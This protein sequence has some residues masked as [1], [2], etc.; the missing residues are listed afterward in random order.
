[1]ARTTAKI[2]LDRLEDLI[3]LEYRKLHEYE[4]ELVISSN[5]SMRYEVR[6]RIATE[7]LPS[8]QRHEI[9][10]GELLDATPW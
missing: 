10:Y 8:L 5:P 1:M 9:E 6:Q 3:R 7:P 4:R 2:H